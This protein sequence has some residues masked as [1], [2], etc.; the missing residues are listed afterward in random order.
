MILVRLRDRIDS[1]FISKNLPEPHTPKSDSTKL[2]DY[3]EGISDLSDNELVEYQSKLNAWYNF[4]VYQTIK[5]R[6]E[7][8]E[9]ET[10]YD[11]YLFKVLDQIDNKK[12][13]TISERKAKA[14]ELDSKLKDTRN[15]LMFEKEKARRLESLEKIID[16][17]LYTVSREFTRR[18]EI[19]KGKDGYHG[20][21]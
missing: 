21:R 20:H 8:A 10:N 1:E 19:I 16:K 7:I 13:K 5:K 2:F 3:I 17:T 6:H 9:L 15:N 18:L 11:D 12:Y 14:I 4:Y